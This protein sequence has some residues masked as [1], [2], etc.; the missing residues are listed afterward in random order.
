[1]VSF[2]FI[3][4][5]NQFSDSTPK[6]LPIPVLS[7]FVS[8]QALEPVME[9]MPLPTSQ[10]IMGNFVPPTLGSVRENFPSS[11]LGFV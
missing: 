3:L 9:E 2:V 4:L 6:D 8:L 11:T 5:S 1:M 7:L 10:P